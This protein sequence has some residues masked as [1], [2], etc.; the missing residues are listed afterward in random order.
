MA[1]GTTETNAC[2]FAAPPHPFGILCP[3]D[4][5]CTLPKPKGFWARV[6]HVLTRKR[7][8]RRPW[9]SLPCRRFEE[10]RR[11]AAGGREGK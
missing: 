9:G 8:C 3:D 10:Y 7:H 4:F 5:E 11:K 6:W 2:P 1:S